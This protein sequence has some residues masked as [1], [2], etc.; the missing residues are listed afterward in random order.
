MA[1]KVKP[2]DQIVKKWQTRAAGAGADYTAGINNAGDSYVQNTLASKDA[3]AAGI[4]AAVSDGRWEK[5]VQG[6]GGA[7]WKKNTVAVGAARFGQGVANATNEFTSAMQKVSS[8]IGGVTLGPRGP[9]GDPQN[10]QRSV[11][12]GQALHAAKISGQL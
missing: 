5:G 1:I 11:A 2:V 12:V 8:V 10:W 6:T 3:Y 9:K 4:T 7:K